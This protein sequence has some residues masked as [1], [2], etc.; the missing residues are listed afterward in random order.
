M[1]DV[2]LV[3][4]LYK[5]DD[6]TMAHYTTD[7]LLED[8]DPTTLATLAASKCPLLNDDVLNDD[9]RITFAQKHAIF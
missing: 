2:A 9:G 8:D 4:Y 7:R 3:L 5:T 6:S 1:F